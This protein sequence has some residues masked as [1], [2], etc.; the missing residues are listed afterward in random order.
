MKNPLK[1]ISYR[2]IINFHKFIL[3]FILHTSEQTKFER[4]PWKLYMNSTL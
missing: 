3:H 1:N 2:N 4:F